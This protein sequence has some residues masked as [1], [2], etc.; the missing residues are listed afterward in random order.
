LKAL[1]GI[2][3]V[4]VLNNNHKGLSWRINF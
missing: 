3:I 1:N 2:A 4:V